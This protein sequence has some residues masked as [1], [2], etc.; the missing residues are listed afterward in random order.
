MYPHNA[1]AFGM[2]NLFLRIPWLCLVSSLA[3]AN[4]AFAQREHS[5][6][7]FEVFVAAEGFHGTGQTY[8]GDADP[9]IDADL[10]FGLTQHQFRV[11]GE[12]YIASD[13]LNLERFQMGFEFVPDTVLWLD[14]FHQPASGWNAEHHHGPYLQTDIT[15]PYIERWED[16]QG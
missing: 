7:E 4:S 10:V 12:Y 3:W 1:G 9:W 6:S 8:A 13:E 11:F 16:E 2:S 14:R 15:R 5:S